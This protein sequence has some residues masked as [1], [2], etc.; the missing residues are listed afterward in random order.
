MKK[1]LKKILGPCDPLGA[2]L[3]GPI[4]RLRGGISKKPSMMLFVFPLRLSIP[5][6]IQFGPVV[7]SECVLGSKIGNNIYKYE[8]SCSSY[9]LLFV[10]NCVTVRKR[11]PLFQMAIAICKFSNA[12]HNMNLTIHTAYAGFI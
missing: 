5:S 4:S 6:F 8:A 2:A 10:F 11:F 7:S 1:K 9:T 3:R 12:C